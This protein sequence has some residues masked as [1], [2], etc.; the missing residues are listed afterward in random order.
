MRITSR[1]TLALA[2]VTLAAA[3]A[4]AG[5]KNC[6]A[7]AVTAGWCRLDTNIAVAWDMP[8]AARTL[9]LDAFA[10]RRGYQEQVECTQ[11]RVD[12]GQCSL[13]QLGQQ[14]ANPESK[15]AFFVRVHREDWQALAHEHR[16]A[17]AA[18]PVRDTELAKPQPD[19]GSPP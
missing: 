6:N 17:A 16:A 4:E 15:A 2:I 13:A 3:P 9:L 18:E 10:A 14:I 11:A 12:A 8:V 1:V 7:A 19:V 5:W